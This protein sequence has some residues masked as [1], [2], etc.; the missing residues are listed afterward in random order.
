M[1]DLKNKDFT[2]NPNLKFKE[3]FKKIDC[4]FGIN[5]EFDIYYAHNEN[6]ELYLI[7]ADINYTISITRLRDKKLV[8]SLS[9]EGKQQIKMIRHFYDKKNNKDYL[10]STFKNANIKIWDLSNNYNLIHSKKID[11]S[12]NSIIFSSILYFSENGDFFITSSNCNDNKDFTKI[13][14]FNDGN[15]VANLT[16]TNRVDIYYMLLWN[17]NN[18]DYL[19]QCSLGIIL[20]HNLENKQL[21][22]ILRKNGNST[23][24]N[25]ACIV[26][27]KDGDDFLYVGNVNG[28]I[29]IWDLKNFNLKK[30]IKYF[31][32]YFYHMITWNQRYILVAEK[33]NCSIII[34]D[35]LYNR[36]ISVL[37]EIHTSFV[38]CL[39]KINHPL[40]GEC[41]LSSDL[42]NQIYLWTH[43]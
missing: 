5:D 8:K 38:I 27:N 42:D 11:Y 15:F 23:I 20:I 24:H 25:S 35:T 32:S 37:K 14:N 33:S 26:K 29:D 22:H 40:Y 41:L 7:S 4:C 1:E 19:I 39:K 28:L 43:K 21:F 3:I 30:S 6:N 36:V 16:D 34:I 13:F 10:I 31:K 9:T 2:T 18:I 12:E 17:N